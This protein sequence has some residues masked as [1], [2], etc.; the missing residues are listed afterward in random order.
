MFQG[1][2]L[3]DYFKRVAAHHGLEFASME[4]EMAEDPG[5]YDDAT[6]YV[7]HLREPVSG[8]I[9]VIAEFLFFVSADYIYWLRYCF[10]NEIHKGRPIHKPFQM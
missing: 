2:N 1:T 4:F 5:S 8:L 7:T 10:H 6:F 3:K 9:R